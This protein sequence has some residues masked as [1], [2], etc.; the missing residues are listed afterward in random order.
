METEAEDAVHGSTRF[1]FL[2]PELCPEDRCELIEQKEILN[3]VCTL[4]E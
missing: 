3:T 1:T 2:P 4:R